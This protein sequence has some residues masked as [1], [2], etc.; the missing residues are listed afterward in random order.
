MCS[1]KF[2]KMCHFLDGFFRKYVTFWTDFFTNVSI[3]YHPLYHNLLT[4]NSFF[5]EFQFAVDL[6]LVLTKD[7]QCTHEKRALFAILLVLL[8]SIRQDGRE[9]FLKVSFSISDQLSRRLV[10]IYLT[11]NWKNVWTNWSP[12]P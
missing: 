2:S 5:C 12:R 10:Y 7:S 6:T 1:T 3:F 9:F 11:L 4:Y 8:S